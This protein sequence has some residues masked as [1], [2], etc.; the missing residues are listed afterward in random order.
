[1]LHSAYES[2][3]QTLSS[4]VHYEKLFKACQSKYQGEG[5]T[6]IL[7]VYPQHCVHLMEAPWEIVVDIVANLLAMNS[8]GYATT[9]SVERDNMECLQYTRV[10][11]LP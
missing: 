10:S 7:L 1:M 9:M 2:P 8:E 6:G 11:L 5:P 3:A 4:A